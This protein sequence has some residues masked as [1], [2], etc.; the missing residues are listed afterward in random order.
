M[1]REAQKVDVKLDLVDAT[2]RSCYVLREAL[3]FLIVHVSKDLHVYT[4]V[5]I[6]ETTSATIRN[7]YV[8]SGSLLSNY[9]DTLRPALPLHY[10]R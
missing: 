3:R 9:S 8:S 5:K 4:V 2:S 6:S 7:T 10:C 1:L